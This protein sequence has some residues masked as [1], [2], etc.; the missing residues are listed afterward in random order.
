M[1]NPGHARA[2]MAFLA[3]LLAVSAPPL[4]AQATDDPRIRLAELQQQGRWQEALVRALR[5]RQDDPRLADEL[6]IDLL[7]GELEERRGALRPAAE[8]FGRTLAQD[9]DLAL[10]GQYRLALNHDGQDHPEVA[11]GLVA[12]VVTG[13]PPAPDL[14][15]AVR[16]LQRTLAA[17]GDCRVLGRIDP[18]RYDRDE[19]RLL[20]LAEADCALRS[21]A[22]SAA[23][24]RATARR[25]YLQILDE[26]QA[27]EAA[28]AAAEGLAT[29]VGD[30]P[31]DVESRLLG[32]TFHQH[33]DFDRAIR[34]LAPL[35]ASFDG[36]LAGDR[37][38]L[39]YTLVRSHFWQDDFAAAASGYAALAARS[40][41]PRLVA[42]AL[43]Q[44][45]R[46]EELAGD[47]QRAATTYRR[48]YR[49]QPLGGTADAALIGA[50]R[51]EWRQGGEESALDLYRLLSSRRQWNDVAAR[52]AL[53]LA[54]SDLVQGRSD[55]AGGWLDDAVRGGREVELEI[56]Y[57]RGRQA[58]LDG[59]PTT[60]VRRYLRVL[61]DDLYHPLALD[62]ADRLSRPPLVGNAQR[63]AEERL[64]VGSESAAYEAWL[65]LA[66]DRQ[67]RA[68]AAHG[69]ARALA[70]D[71]RTAVYVRPVAVPARD[72]V[73]WRQGVTSPEEK[74]LALGLWQVADGALERHFPLSEP[75]LAITRSVLLSLAGAQRDSVR[76]AEVVARRRPREVHEP[77]LAIGLR[78]LL[79]PFPYRSLTV[80]E[81]TARRG[82]PYLLL[83]VMREE[84][85]FDPQALSGASARGLTQFVMP[86]AKRVG[87]EI[88]LG[89][90]APEDLYRPSVAIAL[91]AAYLA[92]LIGNFDGYLPP[93]VASYNAGEPPARMWRSWCYADDAAEYYTKVSYRQT[94]DYLAKVLSSRARYREIYGPG[95]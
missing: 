55:R 50:L 61:R 59:S 83:A 87:A 78:R 47:W 11:A 13:R 7:I 38:E 20:T 57:W 44:Q 73:L 80:R 29:L 31:S 86:T 75:P 43:Y 92:E 2:C 81:S 85:R 67:R 74:L 58:E 14:A 91:G 34:Y 48:T 39:A 84:S 69:L 9:P 23:E 53:F 26:D 3:A 24:R 60:A 22:G 72:W 36:R 56:E 95:G 16:L 45:G 89:E 42:R 90:V 33:R 62:A 27:G 70:T 12:A 76:V 35:V 88:G 82:D 18:A 17:G 41:D 71:P 5:L 94:R 51:I 1:K 52:A 19:R 30:G 66:A 49:A 25:L 6:G 79:Y 28:L 46:C 77:F 21:T 93:A 32:L 64:A 54:A 40:G 68:A 63:I 8:A 4:Q 15:D 65:L 37:Y 10:Y